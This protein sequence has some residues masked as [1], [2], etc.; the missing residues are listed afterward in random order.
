[1]LSASATFTITQ[2]AALDF[3]V[4][5]DGD[6]V[7]KVRVAAALGGKS[8]VVYITASGREIPAET[9]R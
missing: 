3:P 6:R 4:F 8:S 2:T 1:V 7:E 5:A 9:L